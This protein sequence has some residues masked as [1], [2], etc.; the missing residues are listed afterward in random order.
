MSKNFEVLRIDDRTLIV[1][2]YTY[3]S[4]IAYRKDKVIVVQCAKKYTSGSERSLVRLYSIYNAGISY[5]YAEKST[6]DAEKRFIKIIGNIIANPNGDK[7]FDPMGPEYH[8]GRR[9]IR[10]ITRGK[11]GKYNEFRWR[12]LMCDVLLDVIAYYR[13]DE[14]PS[15]MESESWVCEES[16]TEEIANI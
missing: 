11:P 1:N 7:Y 10:V 9:S 5:W 6:K 13:L 8:L 14:N 4:I 2:T 16:S 3:S 12:R 15:D